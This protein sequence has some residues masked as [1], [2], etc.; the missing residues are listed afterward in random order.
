[1]TVS[2]TKFEVKH[3][4]LEILDDIGWSPHVLLLFDGPH[5]KAARCSRHGCGSICTLAVLHLEAKLARV[6]DSQRLPRMALRVQK[7]SS[8]SQVVPS[9][10]LLVALPCFTL[11]YQLNFCSWHLATHCYPDISRATHSNSSS[12]DLSPASDLLIALTEDTGQS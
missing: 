5:S 9:P 11:L 10:F 7:D 4:D 3:H 12:P 6:S 8:E 2:E 1:M